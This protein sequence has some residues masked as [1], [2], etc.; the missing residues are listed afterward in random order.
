LLFMFV[1]LIIP[2]MR[3]IYKGGGVFSIIT[4]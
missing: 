2:E 3:R 4:L 1:L